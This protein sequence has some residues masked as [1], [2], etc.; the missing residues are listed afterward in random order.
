MSITYDHAFD[1]LRPY[2]DSMWEHF[3]LYDNMPYTWNSDLE[4]HIALVSG[5]LIKG[6]RCNI[7]EEPLL[8]KPKEAG[9]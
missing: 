1:L 4:K 9:T 2:D 5:N 8:I 3:H 6:Y 7:T